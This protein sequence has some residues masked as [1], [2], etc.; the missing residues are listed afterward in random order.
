MVK[1]DIKVVI[2]G[3][4]KIGCLIAKSVTQRSGL[5]LVGGVDIDPNL[6]GKDLGEV[7]GIGKNLGIKVSDDIEAAIAESKPDIVVNCTKSFLDMIYPDLV[8][9]IKSKVDVISTC[10]TLVYPYYRYPDLAKNLDELAKENGVT[11]V[12][13]GINPGFMLDVLVM[14][15]TA[16]CVELKSV[17]AKR[18][19]DLAKRRYSLQ[20][21]SGLSLSPEEWREKF[22]KKEITGHVGYAESVAFIAHTLGW[23][24]DKI[25]EWQEPI[26]ADKPLKTEFFNIQPG[27]VAGRNGG[28]R[29][30]LGGEEV[31]RVEGISAV[32]VPEYEE[33]KINGIPPTHWKNEGGTH[34]DLGTAGIICNMIPRVIN[35][36]PGLLTMKDLPLPSYISNCRVAVKG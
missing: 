16:P 13:A 25:E 30:L 34:G 14:V 33:I 3:L 24:V 35:A 27:Q 21:K 7:I 6:I 22:K 36:P 17:Y 26:V 31:I 1:E 12:G 28:A 4:G 32:G 5:K 10:E 29:A 15:L 20:K 2:Q 23:R 11:V 19:L 18:Q 9:I 8:K